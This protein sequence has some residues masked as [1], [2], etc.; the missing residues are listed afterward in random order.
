M[1]TPGRNV[2]KLGHQKWSF[3][4][5]KGLIYNLAYFTKVPNL[6]LFWGFLT[7]GDL[8]GLVTPL[9]RKLT[10]RASF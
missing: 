1:P 3:P 10:S 2:K 9:I 6:T 5:V 7:L 4:V 8:F